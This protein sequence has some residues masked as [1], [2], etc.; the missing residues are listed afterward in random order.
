MTI[1]DW[2]T[3]SIPQLIYLIASFLQNSQTIMVSMR[4][5]IMTEVIWHLGFITEEE[6]V[7]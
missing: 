2:N 3:L 7:K 4:K 6:I 5:D 1:F